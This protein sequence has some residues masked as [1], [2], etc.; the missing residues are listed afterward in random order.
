MKLKRLTKS[1]CNGVMANRLDSTALFRIEG[2][3]KNKIMTL[4]DKS[5]SLIA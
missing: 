5:I 1:T 2:E 4:Y 3:G